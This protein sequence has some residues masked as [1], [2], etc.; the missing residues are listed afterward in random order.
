MNSPKRFA[1]QRRIAA[2]SRVAKAGFA[3]E[4]EA[5]AAT[6]LVGAI[7]ARNITVVKRQWFFMGGTRG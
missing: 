7:A 3:G 1:R 4:G 2:S 5:A 6:W